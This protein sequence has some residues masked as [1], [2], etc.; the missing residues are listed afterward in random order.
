MWNLIHNWRELRRRGVL[1]INRR[2]AEFQLPCNHRKYYPLADNK[3]KTKQLARAAGVAVPNLLGVVQVQQ[4]VRRL[5]AFLDRFSDF[6]VKP[7]CGSGGNGI[8]VCSGRTTAGYR[9]IGGTIL[10]PDTLR[11]HAHDI[12]AGMHSLG[13]MPDVALIEERIEFDTVFAAVTHQGVPD[14]RIILFHGIPVMAM[15]RLPTRESGGKANLH[16]GA[17]GAGL[18][19]AAGHTMTAVW[20]GRIITTHP[21]TGHAVAG[22]RVPHWDEI[23]HI[24]SRCGS[25]CGLGY[26]GA[27]LVLDRRR[28]PLL[29]ELNARPGLAIQLANRAPLLPRLRL[30]EQT[31]GLAQFTPAEKIRFAKDHFGG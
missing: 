23:L 6:V 11:E 1:G 19:L 27:D 24:A 8:L 18:S 20:H 7:A 13:G 10:A 28:G 12:L 22:L 9:R 17:I 14:I 30:I 15:L 25:R 4:Q 5:P 21:D 16:Q 3:L 31:R 29:L 26:L 2:N